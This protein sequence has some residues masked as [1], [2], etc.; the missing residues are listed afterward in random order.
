LENKIGYNVFA[1]D[2]VDFTC[3]EIQSLGIAKAA[4]FR[5]TSGKGAIADKAL[6][7]FRVGW[8]RAKE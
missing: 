2:C 3:L 1:E 5:K 7:F 6:N 8:H 4:R